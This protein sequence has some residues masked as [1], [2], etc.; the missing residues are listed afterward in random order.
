MAGKKQDPDQAAP[1]ELEELAKKSNPVPEPSKAAVD[2][3]TFFANEM[4]LKGVL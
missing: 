4:G 1:E 3:M 2:L